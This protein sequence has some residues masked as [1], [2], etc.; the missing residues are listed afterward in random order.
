MIITKFIYNIN[1]MEYNNIITKT[2]RG[3][4][5]GLRYKI[6]QFMKDRNGVD[7]LF[8]FCFIVYLVMYGLNLLLK[9]PWFFYIEILILIFALFRLFS[10]NVEKRQRE[11]AKFK[12]IIRKINPN[13]EINRRKIV[14]GKTHSFH[15]CPYCGAIL[16]FERK[17]GK[18]NVTCPRCKHKITI[19]NWF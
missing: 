7:A 3:I 18:F 11:N 4:F 2:K 13:Y 10:K 8:Y 9:S 6:N 17:R 1:K 15:E 5:M 14:E 19:K 16:R 12:R